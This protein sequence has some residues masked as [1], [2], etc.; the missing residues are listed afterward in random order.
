MTLAPEQQRIADLFER[1]MGA[2]LEGDLDTTMATMNDNP[3]LNHVPVLA[4]GVGREGVRDF[5]AN[6]LVGKFFPPDVEFHSVSRTVGTDQLV[7]ELVITFT[8]TTEI[9]WLLPGV[10]PTGKRV[11]LAVVAVVGVGRGQDLARAHLLGPG[12]RARPGRPARSGRPPRERRRA[13]AQGARPEPAV[14]R[15]LT[16]GSAPPCSRSSGSRSSSRR[17]TSP[18]R[19]RA[20]CSSGS[21]PAASAT[22]TSTRRRAPTRPATRRACS[23]TRAPASSRRSGEGVTL[24]A[25]GDHVITLFAPE[26]GECVHC[27]SPRTNRCVAI[28][29]QQGARLPARRHD[30]PL[31]RRRAAAAL[32]GHVDVRRVHGDAGDRAREGEP[33]GAAR[34]LR[35]VRLRPLDRDR[36]RA[37][38]RAGRAG[39]DRAPSSA[40]ASSASA[41]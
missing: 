40:A 26:C 7:D 32:H 22:P 15:V 12:E 16:C 28:R 1:H 11:Q 19:R 5:Y 23:A 31:P 21:P 38:H 8:H 9:D 24:V 20:R 37:L 30:A 10:A 34:R 35:A 36:R 27:R 3:H 29:D 33:G 6:H 4:G 2:E 25:P 39:L 41:P 14:A 18:S 13:G 17:S